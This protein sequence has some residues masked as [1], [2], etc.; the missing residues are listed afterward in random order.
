MSAVPLSIAFTA[1]GLAVVNPCGFPLLPA[2]L[3]FYLSAAEHQLPSAPTRI[4]QGLVVGGAVAIGELALF[5]IVGL[6]VTLGVGAIADGVPW[7]PA[8]Q[9]SCRPSRNATARRCSPVPARSSSSRSPAA[10]ATGPAHAQP[11]QRPQNVID[12]A[13]PPDRDSPRRSHRRLRLWHAQRCFATATR[14]QDHRLERHRT[15]AAERR[16]S[17]QPGGIGSA[18][19]RGAALAQHTIVVP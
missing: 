18:S 6:P 4:M 19:C 11:A 15:A 5:T 3:S 16:R 2:F 9:P 8:T 10:F 17:W 14:Q 1:G 12:T 7:R 13:R